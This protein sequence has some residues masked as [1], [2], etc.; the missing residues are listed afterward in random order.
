[1]A[2][3]PPPEGTPELILIPETGID[4]SLGNQVSPTWIFLF[5]GMASIGFGTVFRGL[6]NKRSRKEN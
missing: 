2:P 3:P 1:L 5:L 6:F 4:L